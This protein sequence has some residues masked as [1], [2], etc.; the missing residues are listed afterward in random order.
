MPLS[1]RCPECRSP[2]NVSAYGETVICRTCR[3]W[4]HPEQALGSVQEEPNGWR[5][6]VCGHM[7]PDG[8]PSG[9]MHFDSDGTVR[10]LTHDHGAVMERVSDPTTREG[11]P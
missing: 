5:C 6:P 4:F 8:H 9:G 7:R 2:V 11:R 1:E 3:A 10:H